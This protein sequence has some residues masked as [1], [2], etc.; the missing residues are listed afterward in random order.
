MRRRKQ[1]RPRAVAAAAARTP[2]HCKAVV[3]AA[4][5]ILAGIVWDISWHETIGRDTF[6]TPAHICIHLGGLLGGL[7]C[8]WEVLRATFFG[9]E[10]E[11][12]ASVRVPDWRTAQEFYTVSNDRPVPRHHL[13]LT[14]NSV[15]RI[16]LIITRTVRDGG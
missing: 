5:C 6:W 4:M 7:T 8:G 12:A 10:G 14:R 13:R 3:V 2:W 9:G 15:R 1:L 11:R 16:S